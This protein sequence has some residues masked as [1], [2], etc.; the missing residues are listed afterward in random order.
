MERLDRPDDSVSGSKHSARP[1]RASLYAVA[2]RFICVEGDGEESASL[3][4]RYFADWHVSPFDD[5]GTVAPDATIRVN[6]G[7]EPPR[8]PDGFESFEVAEGGICRTDGREYFFESGG[9][10]VRVRGGTPPLVEVWIGE[11]PRD[12]ERAALARLIFN[13]SMTAM[14]RCGLYELHGAGVVGPAGAGIL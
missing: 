12:R 14:R 6:D 2:G 5:D 13:A 4:R 3:F 9:S 1:A 7:E 11:D 8:A 10:A